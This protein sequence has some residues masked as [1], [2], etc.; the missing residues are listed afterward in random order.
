[1]SSEDL[2]RKIEATLATFSDTSP[3]NYV[4]AEKALAPDLEGMRMYDRPL[5]CVGSADDPL[6]AQLQKPEAVGPQML[7]PN[8]WVEGARSVISYFS[9]T[10]QRIRESN[11]KDEHA[12]IEWFHARIDGQAFIGQAGA[13]LVTYLKELG[14]DACCPAI[15]SELQV[16]FVDE[17]DPEKSFR[18]NWSERHVAYVCGLGTFGLSKG[19]ITKAGMAGRFGSVITTASLP[20][21]PRDYSDIYEYCI[22]CGA[23]AKNCPVGAISLETGKDHALCYGELQ[24]SKERFEGYYGCGKCQVGVPCEHQK[25]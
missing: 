3:A 19:L 2:M 17:N 7:L 21:T 24:A 14:Y 11:R 4:S 13:H 12:S 9:P 10:S 20:V 15:D 1:M 18:S 22:M 16:T 8:D 23:C 5:V 25:P 6:F